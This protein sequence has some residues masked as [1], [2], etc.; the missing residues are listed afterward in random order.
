LQEKDKPDNAKLHFICVNRE[1]RG[2]IDPGLE[3][4]KLLG[5]GERRNGVVVKGEDVVNYK[6]D[7]QWG[8]W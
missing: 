6:G 8:R 7:A 2:T 4:G 3:E 1:R 5:G